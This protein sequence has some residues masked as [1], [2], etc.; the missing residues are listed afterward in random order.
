MEK[1]WIS[2][3]FELSKKYTDYN[4]I[5]VISWENYS[6]RYETGPFCLFDPFYIRYLT[7]DGKI[8]DRKLVSGS[9]YKNY[10]KPVF[11]K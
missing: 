11:I 5:E 4:I 9:L 7:K 1:K 2:E 3:L 8:I 6:F 10:K